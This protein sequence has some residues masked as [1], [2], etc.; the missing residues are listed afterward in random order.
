[1]LLTFQLLSDKEL[2]EARLLLEGASTLNPTTKVKADARF[3]YGDARG[4][5]ELRAALA[6][7]LGRVRGVACDPGRVI[8]TSG[9]AQGMG[10]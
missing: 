9:M 8:V 7:Y 10:R 2:N 3:D 4:A 6:R 1:M 5:P